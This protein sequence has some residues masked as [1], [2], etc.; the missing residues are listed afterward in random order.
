M[1]LHV[2]P[3]TN[4]PRVSAAPASKSASEKQSGPT[5]EACSPVWRAKPG[6]AR[7]WTLRPEIGDP[8]ERIFAA[9]ED[10]LTVF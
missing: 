9:C 1:L 8:A 6:S 7:M 2:E 5:H 4:L 10:A 3:S